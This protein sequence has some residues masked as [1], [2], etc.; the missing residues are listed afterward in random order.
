MHSQY[1]WRCNI[2]GQGCTHCP[3]L[4][5]T[6]LQRDVNCSDGCAAF[7]PKKLELW[8]SS[9]TQSCV[10]VYELDVSVGS[11]TLAET[12]A[13]VSASEFSA[14]ITAS[15]TSAL[16]LSSIHTKTKSCA[17]VRLVSGVSFP[18]PA[19]PVR[20]LILVRPLPPSLP[21]HLRKTYTHQNREQPPSEPWLTTVFVWSCAGVLGSCRHATQPSLCC[22]LTWSTRWLM[23][24]SFS[25]VYMSVLTNSTNFICSNQTKPRTGLYQWDLW[26]CSFTFPAPTLLFFFLDC[27][28]L[29]FPPFLNF[30]FL[31]RNFLDNNF[32][33][34]IL[35]FYFLFYLIFY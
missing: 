12:S 10:K 7:E 2:S 17:S 1:R 3:A 13:A 28:K 4:S 26:L 9:V 30:F 8:C 23:K 19:N 35:L 34:L 29:S 16:C 18:V 33:S 27:I 15:W 5:T 24:A 6:Q 14:E 32:T 21:T 20:L 22:A 25:L 31:T 11:A